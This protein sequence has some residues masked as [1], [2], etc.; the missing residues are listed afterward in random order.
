V[1]VLT[2]TYGEGGTIGPEQIG[3]KQSGLDQDFG[4]AG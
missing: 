3:S 4:Q 2:L 1:V